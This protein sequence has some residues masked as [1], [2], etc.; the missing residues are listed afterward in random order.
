MEEG[1]RE[2]ATICATE[3]LV[4]GQVRCNKIPQPVGWLGRM[5]E[6]AKVRLPEVLPSTG[7]RVTTK[8]KLPARR[9][10]R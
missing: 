4:K 10:R 9:K 2:L 7:V 8:K 3:V 1:I 5:L 6:A